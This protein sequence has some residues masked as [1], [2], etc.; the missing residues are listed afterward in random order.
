MSG[1]D[2]V[3]NL[4]M[5]TKG[6]DAGAE[7]G[8][9]AAHS[10]EHEMQHVASE[11]A[12]AFAAGFSVERGFEA[13]KGQMEEIIELSHQSLRT[14]I[15]VNDLAALRLEAQKTGTEFEAV[16]NGIKKLG[17]NIAESLGGGEKEHYFKELGLDVRDLMAMNPAEQFT[18]VGASIA[19]LE[20]PTSRVHYA[21]ELLGKSGAET[22]NVLTEGAEGLERAKGQL[23]LLSEDD[24]ERVHQAHDAM[25]DLSV[26]G[27]RLSRTFA[28]ELAPG[29]SEAVDGLTWL[30]KAGGEELT[31]LKSLD[32]LDAKAQHNWIWGE[33]NNG[34]DNADDFLKQHQ[35]AEH[36]AM[37]GHVP[38]PEELATQEADQKGYVDET[39]KQEAQAQQIRER[40]NPYEKYKREVGELMNND[41]LNPDE[42]A[43]ALVDAAHRFTEEMER[44]DPFKK[45]RDEA[46]RLVEESSSNFDRFRE[47][48]KKF[49]EMH[50]HGF[51]S[52]KEFDRV[53]AHERQKFLDADGIHG[54]KS[55]LDKFKET[56]TDIAEARKSGIL[57]EDEM[58]KAGQVAYDTLRKNEGLAEYDKGYDLDKPQ[59]H[60]G[61][62]EYGSQ[63]A[64]S[65]MLAATQPKVDEYAR[66][67][68][69]L[70]QKSVDVET[71]AVAV[72]TQINQKLGQGQGF[73]IPP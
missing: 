43:E 20:N 7:H 34:I 70:Q 37:A 64:Y 32:E 47:N 13:V 65:Q 46:D 53:Q 23:G 71:S 2:I 28:I 51:L 35:E 73:H 45:M 41:F 11:I 44:N 67:Q 60:A 29:V 56:L 57:S 21:F 55:S 61:A 66:K 58:N 39:A 3:T 40:I 26:A 10:L 49:E 22:L 52:D 14:G 6:F 63:Q 8:R 36:K 68:V 17:V 1:H 16:Q 69:E 9:S 5:D 27:E 62:Y 31:F 25:I 19:H 24:I 42:F 18:R 33:G 15:D 38:T 59:G 4:I 54:L 50:A 48:Q 30:I 72:L 12:G